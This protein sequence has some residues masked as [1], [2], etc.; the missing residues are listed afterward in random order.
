MES[1]R[2]GTWTAGRSASALRWLS[3]LR[4]A[5]L[6]GEVTALIV[7]SLVAAVGCGLATRF[8]LSAQEPVG[9]VRALAAGS[10]LLAGGLF[11]AGPRMPRAGLHAAIATFVAGATVLAAHAHTAAGL[12]TTARAFQWLAVYCALFLR[13]REARAHALAITLGCAASFA[14]AGIPHTFVEATIVCVTVWVATLMLSALS[15][16][17]RAQADS[18]PLTGLL[19]RGGFTKAATREHA[20]AGRTGAPLTLALLDLDGF[21]HVNDAHGHAAGDRLLSALADA[22]ARTLR[23]GDVL[24]RFGGDEFVAMFPATAPADAAEALARLRAAQ[25]TE[26]SAGVAEWRQGETL[27][28]CL[29]RADRRLYD[30][31]AARRDPL[32][33]VRLARA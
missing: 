23:P 2:A 8:P 5:E 27:A 14:I 33:N 31:K 32:A 6:P 12:M 20:L 9:L 11:A 25:S 24:A 22:W 10:A 4:G 19:N 15:E 28:A 13:A 26:W 29:D 3:R 30:A 7:I 18:D 16:G 21:K 17:L 1:E